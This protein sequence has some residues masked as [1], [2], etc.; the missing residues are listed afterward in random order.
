MKFSLEQTGQ[1]TEYYIDQGYVILKNVFGD[2]FIKPA[3]AQVRRLV[4]HDLP[5]EQWTKE[6][7][8]VSHLPRNNQFDVLDQVYDQ[9][10]VRKIIDTM[11]APTDVWNGD[12]A[13]QLFI[14]AFDEGAKPVTSDC[15]HIDFVSAPVPVMGSGFMFQA[16]LVKSEPFSGNLTV[17]PGTHKLLQKMLRENPELQW[18]DHKPMAEALRCPPLEFVAEPGDVIL[19]HHLVGH[20]GNSNHAAHR[21][22]RCVLHC[23]GLRKVWPREIDPA[24]GPMSP[25]ERSVLPQGVRFRA[26]KDELEA[27]NAWK[28]KKQKQKATV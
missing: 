2:E 16:S 23:Q 8:K 18:P 21:L 17:Y 9:P 13:Y 25:W 7:T 3:L 12:R 10:G 19:F 4:G 5:M 1:W 20:A 11:F 6:N 15:G 27:I 26:P 28:E 14:T 24:S 22:P